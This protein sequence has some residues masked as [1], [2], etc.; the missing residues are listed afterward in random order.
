MHKALLKL[1]MISDVVDVHVGRNRGHRPIENISCE[2]AKTCDAQSRIDHEV[3]IA[4]A[5]MPDVAAKERHDIRLEDERDVV[6][7]PTKLKPSFG[8]LEHSL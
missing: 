6:I 5:H 1:V 7:E 4:S 8:D 2:L 3:A